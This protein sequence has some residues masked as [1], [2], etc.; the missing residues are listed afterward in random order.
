MD[1]AAQF[2]AQAAAVQKLWTAERR[3]HLAAL[4]AVRCEAAAPL[5]GAD[6]RRIVTI[7]RPVADVS[8]SLLVVASAAGL[9][10]MREDPLRTALAVSCAKFYTDAHHAHSLNVYDTGTRHC[11]TATTLAQCL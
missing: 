6:L 2:A 3:A 8:L 10:P 11:C 9:L 5:L 4:S 1:V 7:E